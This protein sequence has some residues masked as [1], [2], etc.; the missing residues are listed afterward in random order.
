MSQKLNV[1]EV[2][3]GFHPLTG[4][5][6]AHGV[7]V[8]YA[9]GHCSGQTP[10]ASVRDTPDYRCVYCSRYLCSSALCNAGC[11]PLYSLAKDR[12][13]GAEKWTK[14]LPAIMRGATTPEQAIALGI[15]KETFNG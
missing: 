11:T 8:F 15:P 6:V 7:F 12:F 1:L 9:C 13:E 10:L 3:N 4:E 2:V 14:L 5:P